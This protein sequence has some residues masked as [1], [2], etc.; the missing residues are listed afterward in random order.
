[1]MAFFL[2]EPTYGCTMWPFIN[3]CICAQIRN[4]SNVFLWVALWFGI[5]GSI[6]LFFMVSENNCD[7]AIRH[8]NLTKKSSSS[9]RASFFSVGPTSN[10]QWTRSF[11]VFS[12]V[13]FGL[14]TFMWQR[15]GEENTLQFGK[16]GNFITTY[17]L[18]LP[19]YRPVSV[20]L[21]LCL[22]IYLNQTLSD[23]GL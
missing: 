22:I 11:Q 10:K 7:K 1:M 14:V 5:S 21:S 4:M 19:L 9:S 12:T 17:L 13:L 18:Y 20:G 8:I 3:S 16:I 6:S 15:V 23:N 2:S